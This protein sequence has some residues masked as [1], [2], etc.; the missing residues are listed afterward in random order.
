M[1]VV[2]FQH[3]GRREYMPVPV[4]GAMSEGPENSYP[5]YRAYDDHYS[6]NGLE[7][8][9]LLS[10]RVRR[11]NEVSGHLQIKTGRMVQGL[12]NMVFL[13]KNLIF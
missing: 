8:C 3:A 9:N 7:H 11:I 13:M 2:L 1:T 12:Q 5:V 4:T 6:K 10:A